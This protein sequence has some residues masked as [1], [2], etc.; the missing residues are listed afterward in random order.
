MPDKKA[1]ST[2]WRHV[3]YRCSRCTGEYKTKTNWTADGSGVH[4]CTAC[5]KIVADE[6]WEERKPRQKHARTNSKTNKMWALVEAPPGC[7]FRVGL[8]VG[9][10]ELMNLGLVNFNWDVGMV[11]EHRLTK[12]RYTVSPDMQLELFDNDEVSDDS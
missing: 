3:T 7:D 2:R 8:Q 5:R 6:R 12:R 10:D 11:F 4:Y 9:E 1:V